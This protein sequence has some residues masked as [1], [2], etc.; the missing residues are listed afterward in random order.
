MLNKL[1][2]DVHYEYAQ[3]YLQRI[4][5]AINIYCAEAVKS[6]EI[7]SNCPTL[8]EDWETAAFKKNCSSLAGRQNCSTES[9]FIYHC[10]INGYRNETLS[11]CAPRRVIFG[12]GTTTFNKKNVK[13][14]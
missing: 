5:A 10:V 3:L 2:L 4:C 9:L 11:V 12:I 1:L 13:S 8:K 14:N 6:V 7:V